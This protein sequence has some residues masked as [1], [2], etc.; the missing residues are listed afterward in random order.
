MGAL[1]LLGSE[2]ETSC[3]GGG[4]SF[5]FGTVNDSG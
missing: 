4:G 5:A 3:T 1:G 2:L